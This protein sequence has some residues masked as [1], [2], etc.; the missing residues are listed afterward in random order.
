MRDPSTVAEGFTCGP[1]IDAGHGV[2]MRLWHHDGQPDSLEYDHVCGER[3][4]RNDSIP[5]DPC[6][7]GHGWKV[8]C[9]DPLTLSPSLLCRSCGFHGFIRNG[10]W[11]TA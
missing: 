8:E 9:I 11:V 2:K 10:N 5:L 1:V 7:P 4:E 6:W 3:G